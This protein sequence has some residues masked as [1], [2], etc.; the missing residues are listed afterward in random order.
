MY[1]YVHCAFLQW[2]QLHPTRS[3]DEFV[4]HMSDV[5]GYDKTELLLFLSKQR[6][7]HTTQENG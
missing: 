3:T 1:H 7:F 2:K 5:V 4:D 6:W